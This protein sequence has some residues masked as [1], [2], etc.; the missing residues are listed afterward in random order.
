M[1]LKLRLQ[2][3]SHTLRDQQRTNS[4]SVTRDDSFLREQV[5]LTVLQLEQRKEEG[6]KPER[7]W[8]LDYQATGTPSICEYMGY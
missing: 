2:G 1:M 6:A 5:Q 7:Q 3:A 4:L 8:F